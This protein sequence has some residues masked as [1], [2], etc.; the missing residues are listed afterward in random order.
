MSGAWVS[1]GGRKVY[2]GTS[3]LLHC[4]NSRVTTSILWRVFHILTEPV[5]YMF[6]SVNRRNNEARARIAMWARASLYINNVDIRILLQCRGD[7]EEATEET[8]IYLQLSISSGQICE[9]IGNSLRSI[10][11]IAV[12]VNLSHTH[13]HTR[14]HTVTAEL[15]RKIT[16]H[17]V[18]GSTVGRSHFATKQYKLGYRYRSKASDA[19]R[20]G[21]QPWVLCRT[22]HASRIKVVHQP[23]G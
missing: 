5:P 23:T 6:V 17:K 10:E 16:R 12:T 20:L 21:R 13:T 14:T 19:L 15:Q 18:A 11:H 2:V 22:H 8:S 4:K 9:S 1:G 7:R 3:K